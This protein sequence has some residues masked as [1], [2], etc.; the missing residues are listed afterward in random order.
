MLLQLTVLA[1]WREGA[2]IKP[3]ADHG[4]FTPPARHDCEEGRIMFDELELLRDTL[5]LQRLL[6]HYAEAGAA[7]PEA[8]QD[9]LAHLEGIGPRI[10]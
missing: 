4:R 10:S 7:D 9:R 1:V 3:T 2:S 6:G 8:W 5:E